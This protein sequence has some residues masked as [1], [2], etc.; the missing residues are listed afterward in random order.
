MTDFFTKAKASFNDLMDVTDR[1]EAA[2]REAQAECEHTKCAVSFD[3]EAAKLLKENTDEIRKLW[4]RF[5][6]K[7]PDCGSLLIKYASY[8]H[9]VYGDW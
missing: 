4:P 5:E 8:A 7:C 2:R 3:E 1:L 6:G 9:Y